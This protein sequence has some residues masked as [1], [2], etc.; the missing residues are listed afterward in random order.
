MNRELVPWILFA[1]LMVVWFVGDRLIH[2]YY[3]IQL[4]LVTRP[5]G[6][7]V[8]GWFQRLLSC[9]FFHEDI[10]KDI[11]GRPS[12]YLR[13]WFL[14]GWSPM[15]KD[16]RPRRGIYL[17]HICRPDDDRD[18]HDH[19]WNFT[20]IV[21]RGG[22]VDE[23]WGVIENGRVMVGLEPC[24]PGTIRRRQAEHLHRVQLAPGR[25]S[26]SLVFI[27]PKRR[28]WGFMTE[29]GWV[30]HANYLGA[31]AVLDLDSDARMEATA[32]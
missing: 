28:S 32:S 12:L 9:L 3:K 31:E 26:W 4:A 23:R 2:R 21:L 25:T 5:I 24:G 8:S 16:P 20:T 13:R 15:S 6:L 22:Y 1:T 11:D 14:W 17:H 27:S 30:H 18:P 7:H 29:A 19:P 10:V